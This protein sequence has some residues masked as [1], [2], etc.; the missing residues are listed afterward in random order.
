MTNY[1]S[2]K[3]PGNLLSAFVSECEPVLTDKF[4][5]LKHELVDRMGKDVLASAW[6]RLLKQFEQESVQ[7]KELGSNSVPQIGFKELLQNDGAFSPGFEEEVRK[8][9]CVLVKNVVRV[10]E[11]L[12]WKEDV[13][14]YIAAHS[15]EIVGFPGKT[16]L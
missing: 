16:E 4:I 8:R 11:A 5:K 12:K 14:K 13:K 7:I 10:D 6:D 2:T 9:G 3:R 1:V 15:G